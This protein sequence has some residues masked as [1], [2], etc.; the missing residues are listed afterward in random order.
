MKIDGLAIAIRYE[1]GLLVQAATRG[2]GQ[3]GEDVTQN[4]RAISAIPIRLR[5]N[6]TCEVRGEV[7]MPKKF[8]GTKRR[9]RERRKSNLCKS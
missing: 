1:E 9:T 2:D 5:E 7:Y 4:I 8:C 3:I 6:I